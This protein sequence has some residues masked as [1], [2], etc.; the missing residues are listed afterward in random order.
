MVVLPAEAQDGL[1]KLGLDGLFDSVWLAAESFIASEK[2]VRALQRLEVVGMAPLGVDEAEAEAKHN[3]AGLAHLRDALSRL[4]RGRPQVDPKLIQRLD[5]AV[6][7][8][9]F[10]GALARAR[11]NFVHQLSQEDIKPDD[12]R[13]IISLWDGKMA[14]ATASGFSGLL[15]DLHST[16]ARVEELRNEPN[17][18]RE[19]ASPLVLWKLLLVAGVVL[20]DI[21]AVIACYIWGGCSWIL[22][23]LA[24]VNPGLAA[25][26][27]LGC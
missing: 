9:G 25:L 21:G 8:D 17:R 19:P 10:R 14:L 4:D 22:A 5:K 3:E 20:L 24:A 13:E 1:S 12:F 16:I 23:F 11:E 6:R 2:N 26:V 7:T 27:A 15:G 18:G